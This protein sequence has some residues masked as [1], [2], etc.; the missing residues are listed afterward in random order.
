MSNLEYLTGIC[1]SILNPLP[2]AF[3]EDQLETMDR[4]LTLDREFTK[5]REAEL[6]AWPDRDYF[7]EL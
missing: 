7:R 1:Q 5:E 4:E 6:A 2:P 3:T